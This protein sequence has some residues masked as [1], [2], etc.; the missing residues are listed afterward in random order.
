[1]PRRA[2]VHHCSQGLVGGDSWCSGRDAAIKNGNALPLATSPWAAWCMPVELKPGKGAQIARA[3]GS[4]RADVAR[5]GAM[6][7]SGFVPGEMRK[8]H[9][10]CRAT[11][12]EVWA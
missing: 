5:D 2:P 3:A 6:R 12:G 7:L 8:V 1:M 4:K 10:E 9:V 11:I